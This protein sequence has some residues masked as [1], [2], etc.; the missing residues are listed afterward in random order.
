MSLTKIFQ[1]TQFSYSKVDFIPWKRCLQQLLK[2]K[3]DL[4]MNASYNAERAAN[5]LYTKGY[6]EMR[7]AY[8]YSLKKYPNG[9]PDVTSGATLSKYKICGLAGYNYKS[10]NVDLSVLDTGSKNFNSVTK[11]VRAGR[12]DAFIAR[13]E[14]LAGFKAIGQDYLKGDIGYKPIPDAKASEFYMIISKKSKNAKAL[15]ET[16]NKGIEKLRAD[17][18]LKTMLDKYLK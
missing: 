2:G 16:I 4:V 17:G 3:Y 15:Q 6:Y 5:Y 14:A 10:F 9:L 11:K 1:G 7:P 8:F 12:C 18:E 13:I